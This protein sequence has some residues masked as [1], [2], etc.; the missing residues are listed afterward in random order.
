MCTVQE[1]PNP[2][3]SVQDTQCVCDTIIIVLFWTLTL[4]HCSGHC[5]LFYLSFRTRFHSF[6]NSGYMHT[7][8]VGRYL[9]GGGGRGANFV[10]TR[11]VHVYICLHMPVVVV[12]F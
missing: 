7:S 6:L 10:V 11:T 12:F 8:V 9:G 4:L 5:T 2:S 3:P 1:T